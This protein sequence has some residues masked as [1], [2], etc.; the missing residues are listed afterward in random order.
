[1]RSKIILTHIRNDI[2]AYVRDTLDQYQ[3][4]NPDTSIDFLC[5]L[6]CLSEENVQMF[7]EYNIRL[8]DVNQYHDNELLQ[9][10]LKVCY[11]NKTLGYAPATAYP[12]QPYFWQS[13][14]ERL[15]FVLAHM[16]RE[17]Y[18]N[19]FHFA[20]DNLIYYD[21]DDVDTSLF[22]TT[23]I[24]AAHMSDICTLTSAMF[25]P[26]TE[27]LKVVCERINELFCIPHDEVVATYNCI[28]VHEMTLLSICNKEGIV[29]H[30]DTLPPS[31]Q[32][33]LFDGL[34]YGMYICGTNNFNPPGYHTAAY[35][36]LVGC[37][38]ANSEIFPYFDYE[39]QRPMVRDV[40]GTIHSIFNLHVH[41]KNLKT[42][43]S[44]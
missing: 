10:F 20:N 5:H 32:K 13:G 40:E 12:S 9:A 25:V 27:S 3:K 33:H 42:F 44:L 36:D 15:F 43:M 6:D 18:T 23:R 26:T 38:I 22:D 7:E 24:T 31:K 1:M 37:K 16:E 30:F 21:I 19:V 41:N 35:N 17:G 14:V 4:T 28:M 8:V 2:P 39:K 29:V 34:G 11:L